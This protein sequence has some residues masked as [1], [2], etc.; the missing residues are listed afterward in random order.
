MSFIHTREKLN[1]FSIS[2]PHE[3]KKKK[4]EFIRY[5]RHVTLDATLFRQETSG[6]LLR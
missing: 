4:S 1:L 2:V 3:K 5:R 6:V